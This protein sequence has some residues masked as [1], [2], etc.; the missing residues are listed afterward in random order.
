MSL[1]AAAST[2]VK[3][4]T[5][6]V[7]DPANETFGGMMTL[8]GGLAVV[9]WYLLDARYR[10]KRAK[11]LE[12]SSAP[13]QVLDAL[14]RRTLVY[15]YRWRLLIIH[16][17]LLVPAM[18]W[19]AVCEPAHASIPSRPFI[20]Y[21]P[22]SLF[23]LLLWAHF[24]AFYTRISW[25]EQGIKARSY[26]RRPREIPFSE[27]RSCSFSPLMRC[28]KVRC[29]RHGTLRLPMMMT[30]VPYLLAQLPCD[31]PPYPPGLLGRQR[32]RARSMAAT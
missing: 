8:V 18:V 14:E 21:V 17:W 32:R 3:H 23:L 31:A 19:L 27:V 5:L 30:D 2:L 28:Y 24:A 13:E 12:Q 10:K 22:V 16:L 6:P 25:D 7:P 11:S 29:G 9:S 1:L 20:P 4:R 26:W 15:P